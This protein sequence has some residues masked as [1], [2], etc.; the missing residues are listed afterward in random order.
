MTGFCCHPVFAGGLRTLRV[1]VRNMIIGGA[2]VAEICQGIPI[3]YAAEA[4][5]VV[6]PVAAQ[7]VGDTIECG[8]RGSGGGHMVRPCLSAL[9]LSL[10]SSGRAPASLC[11]RSRLVLS[12]SML[13]VC[14]VVVVRE[15]P[16]RVSQPTARCPLCPACLILG[17]EKAA[18]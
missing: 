1:I 4:S 17:G 9:L 7:P 5:Q 12:W 6:W 16:V 18:R 14:C 10:G 13:S 15:S 3:S 8:W 11:Q 2:S